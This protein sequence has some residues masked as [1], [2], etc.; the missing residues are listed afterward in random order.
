MRS[1]DLSVAYII[2]LG[3]EAVLAVALSVF[4]LHERITPARAATVALVVVGVLWLRRT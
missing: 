3:V 2:V 1:A 4:Y